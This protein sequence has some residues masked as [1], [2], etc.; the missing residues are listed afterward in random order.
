MS[1][2]A[3]S[4][5]PSSKL[6]GHSNEQVCILSLAIVLPFF[7][8]HRLLNV[9]CLNFYI[10]L[11]NQYLLF[12]GPNKLVFLFLL[13]G[14]FMLHRFLNVLCLN[15]YIYFFNQYLLLKGPCHHLFQC[16]SLDILLYLSLFQ[17]IKP[18]GRQPGF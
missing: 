17:Q 4:F 16:S 12:K 2:C 1:D 3:A 9:L 6:R 10:Y 15:F 13:C 5:S 11:F 14:Y 18:R 7:M 8:L